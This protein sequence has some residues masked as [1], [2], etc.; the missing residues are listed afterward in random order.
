MGTPSGTF[1]VLVVGTGYNDFASRFHDG[2][3]AVMQAARHVGILRV[4]WITSREGIGYTAPSGAS[5]ASTYAANNAILRAEAASDR[6]PELTVLDWNAYSARHPDW[7]VSDGVHLTVAG[8]R[9]AAEYVS[10]ALASYDRR[11]CPTGIGG[12]IERGGWC[13]LPG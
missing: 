4:V 10:R 13:S 2:F 11:V 3:G 5:N 8:A 1:D 12:A 6:W 7:V 9:A